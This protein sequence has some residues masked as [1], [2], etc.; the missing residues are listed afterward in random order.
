MRCHLPTKLAKQGVNWFEIREGVVSNLRVVWREQSSLVVR[1][2]KSPTDFWE[3]SVQPWRW[4]SR[5]VIQKLCEVEAQVE[6]VD[7]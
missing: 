1:G 2:D 4:L 6:F 3:E 5:H 7:I